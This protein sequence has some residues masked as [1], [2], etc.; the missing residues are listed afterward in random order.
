MLSDYGSIT[1]DSVR[2][3]AADALAR[4][5]EIVARIVHPS[6]DRTYATTLAPLDEV[7]GIL[8]EAFG[9]TSFMG[10]VHPD[11]GVRQ[12]GREAEETTSKW[13][14][15]L[16]FRDDLFAAVKAFAETGEAGALKGERR[17]LLEFT[18]RD[19]RRAGHELAPDRR[20]R[21][22]ELSNR[23]VEL[24][25]EFERNIAEHEDHLLVTREDLD[26]LP[27]SYVATLEPGVE[28]GTYRVTMA[29]P[30]VI[31]FMDN[32]RRRDLRE[33]LSRKFNSRAVESNR[34]ILEEAIRIRHEIATIFGRPSWAHHRLEDR[35]AKEP[36]AVEAFYASLRPTLTARAAEEIT[37]MS[38]LLEA[39]TGDPLLQ[40]YDWRYYDTRR[41]VTEYGVDPLEVAAYFPLEQVVDGLFEITGEVFGLTYLEVD[42][43]A[44][45]PDVRTY[46]IHDRR[47][48]E[49]LAHVHMDLFPREGKYSHAAAFPLVRGHRLPD[50]S[51]RRPVS[52]IV[53][54]ATKP[55]AD[56]PSL[57]LHDEVE[58]LFH[59]FGHILHQTLTRAELVRFSGTNTE[60]D[61]VEAPSQIMEHWVWRPEVLAR[62]ARHHE[63]GEP[64]P[65][66]L[67]ERLTAARRLNIA[68]ATLR[69]MS[70]GVLDLA[71]HG[72]EAELD[73]ERVLIDA[74]A[75]A[76]LPLH[77]G[78][79]FPASF[80][81]LMG[82][83]DAGYY[84]YLWSEVYGDDMFSRFE[85]EGVTSP[86]VGA[87]YRR[88]ILERGGTV[89]GADLL[90]EFL[91]REP[92]DRAF[93]RHL[94]IEG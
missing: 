29:Y 30:H 75:V 65:P 9:P 7:A 81:H 76:M 83:Y 37:V 6:A 77:E 51:Y 36:G 64:I 31:P 11:A 55:T 92:D 8:A 79:F 32:A 57:L 53:A 88:I 89:D 24:G 19:L 38:R 45:H 23:L 94:G 87:E 40:S 35:M 21:L 74:T 46:A 14:V 42:A 17:R 26:G 82:G 71:L 52:A 60:R 70:F 59:E 3:G 28:T 39:D 85:E 47:S 15:E 18:L 49:R 72:E 61:F 63:T 56:R 93:L 62:F 73:L 48:G 33:E 68:I 84:G 25:V 34:P 80:G 4:A 27:E 78:T 41:R 22:K 13:L 54:N 90:R 86:S 20:A 1:A 16:D 12:S 66:G 67:V 50:G 91:G 58:M 43:P 2:A 69:Q 10:Y 5:E 44:W